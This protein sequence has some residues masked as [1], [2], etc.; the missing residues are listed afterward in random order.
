[1]HRRIAIVLA[2]VFCAVAWAAR[3]EAVELILRPQPQV[4][5]RTICARYGFLLNHALFNQN[6]YLIE[7]PDGTTQAALDAIVASDR[8]VQALEFSRK[9]RAPALPGG[10]A[11]TQSIAAILE[12]YQKT[13]V[14]YY[15]GSAWD[16]Y[17]DQVAAQQIHVADAHQLATG[18]GTIAIIDTGVDPT[19]PALQN[20]LVEGYDF[21]RDLQGF[22]S[23]WNDVP[24]LTQSIAAILEQYRTDLDAGL[25]PPAPLPPYFG[26]GT[27]VAGI[28]HLT[29]PTAK[30]M[31]LKAFN[32]DGSTT[33]YTIIR[34]I[35]YAAD[36]GA[37][38]INMSFVTL[39]PSKELFVA[40]VYAAR[41]GVVSVAAIG[42]NGL[43][44]DVYPVY[45]AEYKTTLGI[46]STNDDGRSR[47]S[48]YGD[49]VTIGAPGE[50]LL[51]TFP[52]GQY[53]QVWGTSFSAGW[54]S[55]SL[56][57]FLERN[58]QVSMKD[59]ST[60]FA[61]GATKLSPAQGMGDGR[62][63]V[64]KSLRAIGIK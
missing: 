62:I 54:A 55:G 31:P 10:A 50:A 2:A 11:L 14:T 8:D 16:A 23:E 58:A 15:G 46:G 24:T 56:A 42:N 6:V 5:A 63:D 48:N 38:V 3:V 30:I 45:P 21:T 1:M 61:A 9:V 7:A 43:S 12:S 22:G 35:Y 29:A 59:A 28:V 33:L 20:V 17:V 41:H 44:T 34:A 25:N 4:A 18:A 36:H 60:A 53:A 47:F 51:T 49:D 32:A 19:H 27:M 37:Q 26:H 57:L 39:Q 13:V 40:L 52:G 64:N